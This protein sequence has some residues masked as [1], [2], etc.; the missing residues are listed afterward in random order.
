MDLSEMVA[1]AV[2]IVLLSTAED[3][4]PATLER[5]ELWRGRG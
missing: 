3:A 1:H 4:H 5:L 2:R